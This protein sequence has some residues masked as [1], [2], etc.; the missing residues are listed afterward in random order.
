MSQMRFFFVDKRDERLEKL[1]YKLGILQTLIPWEIFRKRLERL[2]KDSPKG[3]RPPYDCVMMLKILILQSL[4]NLSDDQTEYQITDSLSFQKFLEIGPEDSVPDAKTIWVFRE[5]LKKEGIYDSL[6][7]EFNKYL[8]KQGYKARGGQM[9]DATFQKVPAQHNTREENEKIRKTET[10]PEEWSEAKKAQKDID[11]RW[12][13]KRDRRYF[14]YKNHVN[15][16]RRHKFIRDYRVTPA[17]V[18]DSRCLD[19]LLDETVPDKGVWADSAYSGEGLE[20]EVRCKGLIPHICEKGYRGRPL[21]PAQK[22]SNREKSRVRSRVEHV[23]GQMSKLSHES[24][25]IYTKG[26][27]RAEVKISLRNLAYNLWR[28]VTVHRTGR[29]LRTCQAKRSPHSP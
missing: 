25:K 13:K 18:H 29:K 6:F 10:A 21:T 7:R 1:G 28:F 17:N 2:Y 4:Y 8:E 12:T 20:A 16:D 23:F 24:R 14:G 22:E 15:V 5:R 19:D 27:Y 9:I 11:A 3:G 26:R